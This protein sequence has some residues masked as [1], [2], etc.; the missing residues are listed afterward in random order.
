MATSGACL[1]IRDYLAVLIA[2]PDVAISYPDSGRFDVVEGAQITVPVTVWSQVRFAAAKVSFSSESMQLGTTSKQ[3][4]VDA[5]VLPTLASGQSAS[6][7]I[8]GASPGHRK[9]Q[10]PPDVYTLS[11]TAAAEAGALWPSRQIHAPSR[12]V[13]VWSAAPSAPHPKVLQAVGQVCESKGLVYVSKPSA[14]G[15]D[16]EFILNSPRGVIT[17]MSVTA[18]AN[19]SQHVSHADTASTTTRK[20]AFHTPPFEKFQEYHYS[21][22][23]YSSKPVTQSDC[24]TWTRALEVNLQDASGEK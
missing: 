3:L 6:V 21:L 22:I 8:T 11:V 15:L 18:A 17:E 19:S 23:L 20:I 24:E 12:E 2:A 16:A 7:K 14:R 5:G 9:M 4:N 10:E 1:G 13:W